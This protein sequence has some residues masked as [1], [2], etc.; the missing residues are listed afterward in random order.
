[1]KR[2]AILLVPVSVW[3]GLAS[4]IGCQEESATDL[5]SNQSSGPISVP[6]PGSNTPTDTVQRYGRQWLFYAQVDKAGDYLR[7]MFIEPA[8]AAQVGR[9]GELPDGTLL[10]METWFGENQS[11]VFIRQKRNGQW[12]SGSFAP[13]SPAFTVGLQTSCNNCH[14]RAESTDLTF[15]RPLLLRSIQQ[16]AF[17]RI[18]CDQPSFTPCDLSVYQ[19]NQ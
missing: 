18:E 2:V 8:V 6:A 11:T 4:I 1:M 9:N 12:L 7:R 15:T 10:L 13:D 3:I 5:I 17:Q 16:R 19:G 14:Q